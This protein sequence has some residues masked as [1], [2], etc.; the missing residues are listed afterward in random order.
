MVC[1][2]QIV[3]DLVI[4]V[5]CRGN[6]RLQRVYIQFTLINNIQEGHSSWSYIFVKLGDMAFLLRRA[7]K[8]HQCIAALCSSHARPFPSIH[9]GTKPRPRYD[10]FVVAQCLIG[11]TL[12]TSCY[13]L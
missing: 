6:G 11:R 3:N 10:L 13:F 8:R 7:S 1:Q 2:S 12:G 9:L 5:G 4:K